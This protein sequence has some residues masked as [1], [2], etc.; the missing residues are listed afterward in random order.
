MSDSD[1]AIIGMAGRFPGARNVDE[2]WQNLRAGV[3][4]IERL[5]EDELRA[6]GEDPALLAD[7]A[8]VRACPLLADIDKFDARFF[9]FSPRDAAITD[10][11]HRI[12]LE[13]AWQALE[14][15][16]YDP[17]RVPG[18]VGVYAACGMNAYMMFHL[19]PNA[20]VMRTI[21][22]WLVR[23]TGNDMNFLA[24]RVSYEMNLR[25]PSMNVQTACSSSLTAVHLAVQSLLALE[26]DMALCGG[27]TINLP[28]GRGYLYKP[29]EILSPDGHCRP[30]AADSQGTVFGSGAGAV[31]LKRLS[32]AVAQGDT[33][34]A[35]IKA[36]AI[37]NDGND[38][39]GYLAPSVSGQAAVVSEALALGDI[40]PD[41]VSY[42]EAHGTGTMMGDPIEVAALCEAFRVKTQQ[43]GFCRIGSV[44]SNI[45]HLGE[46]AGIASLIK[47]ICALRANEIP[48][49]L[50]CARP[51]PLI[52]FAASPFV[53]AD[54]LVPWTAPL[55][56][57]GITGLG[58]GGT[59]AHLIVEEAPAIAALTGRDREH[60]FLLSAKSPSAL[61]AQSA[62]L[63]EH[64][65]AHLEQSLDDIAHTL[66]A[67]RK[68][69]VHR[70]A[71]AARTREEASA[72]LR[73]SAGEVSE[74]RSV[75]FVFPGGGAQYAGMGRDL[76]RDEPAYREA[77]DQSL[78]LMA[79]E[80]RSVVRQLLL[81]PADFA[82][83]T[84][85]LEAP[86]LAL[87]AL[88]ATEL[89]LAKLFMS[90]G[91]HPS[92]LIGHSAG[93][94]VAAHLAGVLTHR[95]AL[96]LVTVRG[97]LFAR[98]PAGAMLAVPLGE[99][100]LSPLLG[101][102]LS[103]AA[104][105]GAQSTVA[106]GP[107]AAIA[108]LE[109]TLR[110]AGLEPQRV[111]IKVAA[112][113]AMLDPI[114][115]EFESVCSAMT[116]SAPRIPLAANLTGRWADACDAR[117]WVR[118]LRD[119]VRF[120][121][122][123][124]LLKGQPRVLVEI[125]PGRTLSAMAGKHTGFPAAPTMRHPQERA[126]DT[127][128]ALRAF[129]RV[130][131]LG[132][133]LDLDARDAHETRARVPLPQYPFEGERFWIERGSVQTATEPLRKRMDL[134]TWFAAPVW[135]AAPVVPLASA[136]QT[137][138]VFCDD[139]A[140]TRALP[141]RV[142]QVRAGAAF[143]QRGDV[144]TV[145]PGERGDYDRLFAALPELTQIIHAWGVCAPLPE[146][147]RILWLHDAQARLYTS[148]LC[149][150]Q[151]LGQR[152]AASTLTIVS[153]HAQRVFGETL[154]PEK[155]LLFGPARVIA[156]EY[157]HVTVRSVDLED[158]REQAATLSAELAHHEAIVAYRGGERF[159]QTVAPSPL[160]PAPPNW[161]QD[162]T[163]LITGGL[164]GIGLVLAKHMAASARVKLVL[165]GRQGLPA[166]PDAWLRDHPPEDATSQRIVAVRGLE[167][168][169]AEVMVAAANVTDLV[170]LRRVVAQA[171][172]R[173]GPMTGAIHAAG[174][175]HDE[176]IAFRTPADPSAVIDTKLRGALALDAVLGDEARELFV[177]CSSV[178]ARLGLPGQI[179]YTAANAAL[180]A[181]AQAL[182][183]RRRAISIAWSAWQE[184][185]M[186]AAL[187]GSA[188]TASAQRHHGHP[189]LEF[190][191]GDAFATPIGKQWLVTEH[192][193]AGG[194]PVIPG[195]GYL[196]LARAGYA[197]RT[198]AS[199]IELR[200]VVF[201]APFV[202]PAGGQNARTLH[203]DFKD[204]AFTFTSDAHA[205][206][207]ASGTARELNELAEPRDL[208]AIRARCKKVAIIDGFLAQSFVDFGPRWA[209]LERIAYGDGE[210]LVELALPDAFAADLPLFALHPALLDMATGSAQALI[211]GFAPASDFL[212]P[213]AYE[214]VRSYAPL[215]ARIASHV[216]VRPGA[217]GE[218]AIFDVTI[219][220]PQGQVLVD[221]VGFTMKR[222]TTGWTLSAA[223][224][225]PVSLRE[226]VLRE[227]IVP[228]EGAEAFARIVAS[229]VGA[230]IIASSVD[231]GAWQREV[232]MQGKGAGE[233]ALHFA[234][235]SLTTA[236]VA[237]RTD[238]E[239]ALAEMWQALLGLD[240]VGVDD[241]FFELGGESLIAV[242]LFA[243]IRAR[244]KIDL[245]LSTL[246][247]APT[248][249]ACASLLDAQQA[250]AGEGPVAWRSLVKMQA[251]G[252][253]TPLFCVAGMG[254]NP[255][256][257]RRLAILIGSDRPFYGLQPPGLDGTSERLYEVEALADH[258]LREVFAVQK[259]GP[260]F[261]G[262][263]SGG[264][265]AAFA[266]AQKLTAQGHEVGFLGFIDSFSP[267]LPRKS[268][269]ERA[270]LH[271]RRTREQG[272]AYLADTVG[273][274]F[275]HQRFAAM[276]RVYRALGTVSPER[277]RYE[278]I[279]D[280]WITA[281]SRYFPKP[282][283]G[284]AV[285]FRA[286]EESAISLWSAVSVDE[287]HGWGRYVMR[288]VEVVVV[289]GNHATMCDEPQVQVLADEMRK[290]LAH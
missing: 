185:G 34:L 238:T 57:A 31:I 135:H 225:A 128:F 188:W 92:A 1:I 65:S 70:R 72:A 81:E 140:L 283:P 64:L 8:Y 150:A 252:D 139:A 141:G 18:P 123:L 228:H 86:E 33:V 207:H 3:E 45:G 32:D 246:F 170:A 260:F 195:T 262:G 288:G 51:N 250:S 46:A 15:A 197:A 230:Q 276:R 247:E 174:T 108:E 177:L 235:P 154:A 102:E 36:S 217:S 44:K 241:D 104:V 269:A 161:L 172:A 122:G 224:G 124:E 28:H 7:P 158:G 210:A 187:P 129:G 239:R 16:G 111:H 178:S 145:Q 200:Q 233:S 240:T 206:P 267:Q 274:R 89:A 14:N 148:L 277:Y 10:P 248:I 59:N 203:L 275:E 253:G 213:F 110:A 107:V 231:I 176:L 79:P 78:A 77:L 73:V 134:S 42:I 251:Q 13:V 237:P 47:V 58:A 101:A 263:Y 132:A 103:L 156:H 211:A 66:R 234:R 6:A 278:N 143:A 130:W 173:F 218:R 74:A 272:P 38:K 189:W 83:D 115:A 249:A 4:S 63:A 164:G 221:I 287:Q 167:A 166:D 43:R 94:Y 264:G 90:W 227:G 257:L 162:G 55:K 271:L 136:A 19:A 279:G 21:G 183:P 196:E 112:H 181:L 255:A 56:R 171:R 147:K 80:L 93:E 219:C 192:V 265:V 282:W 184:V 9:G 144:F 236:M 116:F 97:Q 22:E 201:T 266:M 41:S 245:P 142:L 153:T 149:L 121:D 190:V 270:L 208:A 285:L 26:C 67:G 62:L 194:P 88:F 254:G 204:D 118:H 69:F 160:A 215:Q 23:H 113:S 281:E 49:T 232:D 261:L 105:N 37:N 95:D 27:T 191:R 17:E 71:V 220:T 212:V 35:V 106:A 48:P 152:E 50:H 100:E 11:Q 163:Y 273:R 182:R 146:R 280:S 290:R 12:F 284:K 54:T 60:L 125:G 138:L 114:L 226:I 40:E 99:V 268:Y 5:S 209:N 186:A 151:V 175:L 91:M 199:A 25:G 120:A 259:E 29:G 39:V 87:P 258:Y 137:W 75:V 242:Q 127:N 289:P 229:N 216:R 68:P 109:A 169:G 133:P 76:Y 2:Y 214:A 244:F 223:P 256:N 179:D 53:V 222:A 30:F 24:T 155:A 126:S 98:T 165:I 157:P 193:V 131:A 202:A 205:P 52:D 180:D 286:A 117:Y 119:T 20:E 198:G 243:K 85:R 84:A 96:T 168:A 82:A 61:A 159:L